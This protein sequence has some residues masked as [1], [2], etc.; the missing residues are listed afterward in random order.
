MKSAKFR[1]LTLPR[2]CSNIVK[3]WWVNRYE[4][5]WKFTALHSSKKVCK[6]IKI[7]DKVTPMVRV[8]PFLTRSVCA[9]FLVTTEY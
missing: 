8:A 7:I 2:Y 5:C 9:I 1:F 4:F 6:S 3:V